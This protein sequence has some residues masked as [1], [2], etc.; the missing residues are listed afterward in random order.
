MNFCHLHVHSEFSYLDGYGSAEQY[1]SKAKKLGMEYIAIT[2]HGCVDGTLKWQKECDKQGI[3]P[4]LGCEFYIVPDAN[5]KKKERRGHIII[6]ARNLEG[7]QE[8]CRL[9]TKAN[10]DGF[11][12][13]PRIDFNSLLNADLSG[14]V[15]LTACAASFINL[16]GGIDLLENLWESMKGRLFLEIMPHDFKD[17]YVLNKKL[18]DLH[19]KFRSREKGNLPFVA[20]NDCHYIEKEDWETQ[21]VLLAIGT[22]AKWD[23]KNRFKFSIKDLHLKSPKEMQL[24][25]RKHCFSADQIKEAMQNT[26]KIAEMCC[27]FRIPKQEISLPRIIP[28][29]KKEREYLYDICY[30]RLIDIFK[31]KQNIPN[32][33]MK[34]LNTE[35]DLIAK[36]GFE[37]YFIIVHDVSQ[38]SRKNN[39]M[40][41]PR[42]SVGG[43]V[44][45][46]L[47]GITNI[48]PMKFHL[49]FARFIN[50]DRQD[51]PD[52]DIDFEKNKRELVNEYIF[53]KYGT[54]YTCGISTEMRLKS[55]AALQA[56]SRVFKIPPQDVKAFSKIIPEQGDHD[57]GSLLQVAIDKEG[58]WFA[59]K[60]PK[61]IKFALKMENQVRGNGKHAAAVIVSDE[62]LTQGSKC[63]L[64]RRK[65]KVVCNWSMEDSEYVGLMKLDILGI[66]TLCVLSECKRL[67]LK[68]FAHYKKDVF[69]FN[70][71]PFDDK[72][73]FSLINDGRTSGLFHLSAQHTTRVCKE[74]KINSFDDIV[75]SIALARPGPYNSG[76]TA[77][78]IKRKHGNKWQP[79]HLIYEDVTKYTYGILVF[80]EQVMQVI[81]RV[82]GLSESTADKIRKVIGKKRD[83]KEFKPYWIQFKNGCKKMKT[84]SEKEAEAFWKGLLEWASYGFNKAHSVAYAMIGY[85][86][87]WCKVNYPIEFL[88]AHL[89]FGEFDE[90]SSDSAKHKHP[91]LKEIMQHNIAVMPPKVGISDAIKWLAKDNKIYVP[92]IEIKGV[93]I[94]QAEKCA[95]SKSISAPRL[96]GF[97]GKEYAPLPKEKSKIDL[98]LEEI[99]AYDANV[100]PNDKILSKYLPFKIGKTDT[101]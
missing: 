95:I 47:L 65:G 79:K 23:D 34:H 94:H 55:R 38:W 33:Y 84:L 68:N 36:K 5:I 12:S 40:M 21:E 50:K 27:D 4:I 28:K 71:I 8:L 88:C 48:D 82:A 49:S 30:D 43:S 51:Y 87:A 22:G 70:D 86:T 15:I 59:K 41:G 91:L 85:W 1:I 80:Q 60:Y 100:I 20:T 74:I 11:Y 81:S 61:V 98:M 83:P 39:I 89:S 32:E 52:I 54:K 90:N 19:Y 29:E 96:E 76:M 3:R 7:W 58:K 93:G 101:D 37:K 13:K 42:G 26:I 2:D 17:Q 63:V 10:L 77:D 16:P 24:S 35:L 72:K 62:D 99:K 78:Y 25:F 97:F 66:S 67:I 46:Y 31:K 45:A 64:V 44:L 53:N 9:L 92:F 6:L 69:H 56:V 73:V 14:L 18:L 75:V 57:E